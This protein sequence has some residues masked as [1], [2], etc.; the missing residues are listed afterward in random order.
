M[1]EQV[2]D[3]PTFLSQ[4]DKYFL[5]LSLVQV[6][7]VVVIGMVLFILSLTLPFGLM[8]R[9]G[10]VAA[11]TAVGTILGFVRIAGLSVPGYMMLML[12]APLRRTVYEEDAEVLLV[13]S[14]EFLAL[15]EERESRQQASSGARGGNW[16]SKGRELAT[17][18][19]MAARRGEIAVEVNK[20][21]I[22]GA[23]AVEGM[24]KD[25]LRSLKG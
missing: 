12:M 2:Y 8:L 5:G 21:M 4:K 13:G 11:G 1:M 23:Q 10:F 9:I 15:L 16:V 17:G 20:G 7:G 3:S 22:E 6:M 14:S 25:G 24:L 18:D 19:E